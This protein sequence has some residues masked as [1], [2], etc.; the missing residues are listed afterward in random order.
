M[1]RTEI[2]QGR[3]NVAG[4]QLVGTYPIQGPDEG[5]VDVV[6]VFYTN[7]DVTGTWPA[8]AAFDAPPADQVQC[9]NPA[10]D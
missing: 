8:Q 9:L 3:L 10:F 5:D 7:A 6:Q 2:M 1:L 4:V